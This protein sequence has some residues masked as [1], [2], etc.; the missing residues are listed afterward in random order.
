MN[1]RR[2][3]INV[4]DGG[5]EHKMHKQSQSKKQQHIHNRLPGR[6]AETD[7]SDEDLSSKGRMPHN[8]TTG[9]PF[10][11]VTINIA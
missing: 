2:G 1:Q 7:T 6:E 3:K 10:T 11:M 9:L 4:K 5:E 8:L